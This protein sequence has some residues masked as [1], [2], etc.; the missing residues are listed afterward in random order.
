MSLF[1]LT[2]VLIMVSAL[3]AAE[4]EIRIGVLYPLSGPYG[5]V[6][7]DNRRGTELGEEIIN[8]KHPEI[9]LPIAKWGGIPS[10]GGAKIKFIFADHRGE[11]DRG[12]DLAKKFIFD[13]KVVGLM[14]CTFSS[15]S[16]TVSNVAE[17]YGIP[18]ICD[19]STSPELTRRGLKWLWRTYLDDEL[20]N[21]ELFSLLDG[22]SKGKVRGVKSVPKDELKNLVSACENT[23]WGTNV[24]KSL[25]VLAKK[26]DYNLVKG[27]LYGA[28]TPDLTSEARLLVD[29]K[30]D[31]M[32]FASYT[33]DAI[34]MI[35]TLRGMKASPK[36]LWGQDAG[37]EASDFSKNLGPD[38]IGILTRSG[39][40]PKVAK[41][42]KVFLQIN[43]LF[44]K[45][46]GENMTGMSVTLG[47]QT[48]AYALNRAGSTDPKAIQKALNEITIPENESMVPTGGVKF[49]STGQN[50]L[51]HGLI[52]QYQ[53]TEEGNIGSEVVY[54]FDLAT[55]K[56]VYP[57]PGWK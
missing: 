50:I 18:M 32:L 24:C 8:N 16:K 12:A 55:A 4:R 23:E 11:P 35:R 7:R 3:F 15:V 41:G 48:W 5:Q 57:F 9:D 36:I 17:R 46:Y 53:K 38:C 1:A 30:P 6:G 33:S 27:I 34:L 28:K 19:S 39:F 47:P 26:N 20:L 52:A 14:G 37:F 54:P 21:K 45:R 10:L 44:K 49:D 56:M 42:N 2:L 40:H 29:A 13:E 31:C 25:A 22:L 43:D 51:I